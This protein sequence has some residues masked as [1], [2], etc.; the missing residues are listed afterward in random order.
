[1]KM[2]FALFAEDIKLLP[3]E[4]MSNSL[5]QSIRTPEQFPERARALFRAMREGGYF[6]L[7]RVPRFN[8]WLFA[9]D[10]VLARSRRTTRRCKLSPR[11]PASWCACAMRG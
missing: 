9:D 11:P 8:G 7:D 10:E 5:K 6:G 3:A 1:M 2:L 4:L